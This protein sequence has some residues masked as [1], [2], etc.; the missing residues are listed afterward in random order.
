M[1]V[2]NTLGMQLLSTMTL[3]SQPNMQGSVTYL[4]RRGAEMPD[5]R[6]RAPEPPERR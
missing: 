2:L 5:M 6:P 3:R 1:R 4:L